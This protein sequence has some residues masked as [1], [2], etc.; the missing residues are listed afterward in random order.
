MFNKE[1]NAEIAAK[2]K[3]LKEIAI[4][5]GL[6]AKEVE[7]LENEIRAPKGKVNTAAADFVEDFKKAI[8]SI[9]PKK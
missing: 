7:D 2:I 8:D 9:K 1:F 5:K 4:E 3:E 6:T